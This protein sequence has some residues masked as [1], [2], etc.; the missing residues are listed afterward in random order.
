MGS[1]GVFDSGVGG[2]TVLAALR[3]ILPEV[4]L[5][6]VA[7]SANAPYGERDRDFIVA[8][9]LALTRALRARGAALVVIACNTAT[10]WAADEIRRLEPDLPVVGI[11]PGIK[12]AV[13][14]SRSGRVGVLATRATAESPRFQALV[15]RHAGEAR[16][17]VVACSGVARRIEAGD[18]ASD[19]LRE[20]IRG[21]C[22]PLLEA[23][24]DTVLLGCT[25][26]PLVLPLWRE[27]LGPSIELVQV[28]EAVARQAARMWKASATGPLVAPAAARIRLSTTGDVAVLR[29]LAISLGLVDPDLPCE[30]WHEGGGVADDGAPARAIP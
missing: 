21:Y 4:A 22:A 9:S 18:L 8:R 29:T 27:A 17:T 23:G 16:V 3:R 12:P 26:Y 11:E 5:D 30:R 20:L 7:D 6:Y 15:A 24:V 2:L 10:A 25:H 1:I 19:G 13:Q 28:E 14:R